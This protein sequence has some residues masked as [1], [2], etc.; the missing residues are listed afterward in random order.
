MACRRRQKIGGGLVAD[1]TAMKV[2]Y[3]TVD[4]DSDVATRQGQNTIRIPIS[5]RV[6]TR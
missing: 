1:P 4:L 2:H 3:T 5:V 6:F